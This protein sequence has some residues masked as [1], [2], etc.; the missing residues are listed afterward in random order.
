MADTS[1]TALANLHK[2]IG[3]HLSFKKGGGTQLL[4]SLA[5]THWGGKCFL[6]GN[7]AFGK[8]SENNAVTSPGHTH[9]FH[10]SFYLLFSHSYLRPLSGWSRSHLSPVVH[11]FPGRVCLSLTLSSTAWKPYLKFCKVSEGLVLCH[12]KSLK[13]LLWQMLDSPGTGNL[14]TTASQNSARED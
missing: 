14:R 5:V 7:A 2:P 4:Y 8:V 3:W 6:C 12:Q 1:L 9:V 13:G 10:V 11:C